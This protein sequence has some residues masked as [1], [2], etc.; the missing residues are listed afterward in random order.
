MQTDAKVTK[1]VSDNQMM[2]EAS[3]LVLASTLVRTFRR[4]LYL[5]DLFRFSQS[6]HRNPIKFVTGH[7]IEQCFSVDEALNIHRTFQRYC[8]RQQGHEPSLY[9]QK[10]IV[11]TYLGIQ[12]SHRKKSEYICQ[13]YKCFFVKEEKGRIFMGGRHF[14]L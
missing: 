3:R 4:Q 8:H 5:V 14:S 1:K 12:I 13:L 11:R 10:G 9:V 2:V 7:K 6:V